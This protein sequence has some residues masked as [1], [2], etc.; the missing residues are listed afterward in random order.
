MKTSIDFTQLI[1][2]RLDKLEGKLDTKLESFFEQ[3][4]NRLNAIEDEVNGLK[5]QITYMR[6]QIFGNGG[7]GLQKRQEELEKIVEELCA[8][9]NKLKIKKWD[10]YKEWG[11]WIIRIVGIIIMSIVGSSV[12]CGFPSNHFNKTQQQLENPIKQGE[13]LR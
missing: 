2:D 11:A 12:W 1:L 8:T 5:D 6:V 3:F 9:N 10:A 7:K 13:I 4:N